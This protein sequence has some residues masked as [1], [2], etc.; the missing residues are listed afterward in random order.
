MLAG[1]TP[2][3]LAAY[4]AL[5]G[6]VR[7]EM[8]REL[9]A[10]QSE[11]YVEQLRAYNNTL[12][13]QTVDI[14]WGEEAESLKRCILGALRDRIQP[15]QPWMTKEQALDIRERLLNEIPVEGFIENGRRRI[16]LRPQIRNRIKA[17]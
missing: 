11:E 9:R 10:G 16:R 15:D 8:T 3:Q 17:R 1:L 4:R 14:T 7:R 6:E 5:P 13:Y 2:E 12:R